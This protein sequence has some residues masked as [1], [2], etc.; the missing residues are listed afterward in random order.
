[1]L[2]QPH[3]AVVVTASCKGPQID[4]HP[5][6]TGCSLSGLRLAYGWVPLDTFPLSDIGSGLISVALGSS[7]LRSSQHRAR[8][9]GEKQN[10]FQELLWKWPLLATHRQTGGHICGHI[11]AHMKVHTQAC[12][13]MQ[14]HAAFL[15]GLYPRSSP[16]NT[17]LG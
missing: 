13:H 17:S 4:P 3:P 12:G 1:M 8:E 15:K 10:F 11:Q 5:W 9:L 16:Q 2:F 7:E 14:A 6:D